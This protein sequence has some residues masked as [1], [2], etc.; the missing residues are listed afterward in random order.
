MEDKTPPLLTPPAAPLEGGPSLYPQSAAMLALA[1]VLWMIPSHP[2]VHSKIP[3][4]DAVFTDPSP[5]RKISDR[6]QTADDGSKCTECHEHGEAIEDLKSGKGNHEIKLDHGR[7]NRCFHCHNPKDM[8]TFQN[9]DGDPV[10]YK[11]VVLMC[12]NCHGPQYRDWLAGI[13]G[14]RSGYY[15]TRK[16]EQKT[17]RCIEC[18]NPHNPVYP[19]LKPAP[20]PHTLHRAEKTFTNPSAEAPKPYPAIHPYMTPSPEPSPLQTPP[21]AAQASPSPVPSGQPT[22][23]QPAHPSPTPAAPLKNGET[24]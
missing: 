7:N 18:H 19:R 1:V 20:G 23:Q 15:D 13:H 11:D 9:R 14:R 5:I 8:D 3:P 4:V 16:G 24:P 2:T 10:E 22:A 12:T 17:L 21:A 6:L